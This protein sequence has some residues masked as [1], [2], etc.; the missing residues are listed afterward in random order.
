M[1]W[2]GEVRDESPVWFAGAG[3]DLVRWGPVRHWSGPVGRGWVRW[4]GAW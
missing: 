1:V 2:Y 4:G 3:Y